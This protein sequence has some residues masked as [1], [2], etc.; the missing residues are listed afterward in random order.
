MS[1]KHSWVRV[2]SLKSSGCGVS[3]ASPGMP[4]TYPITEHEG[5][6]RGQGFISASAD[7]VPHLEEQ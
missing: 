6:R 7:T 5:S 2:C 1:E 4:T 3:V